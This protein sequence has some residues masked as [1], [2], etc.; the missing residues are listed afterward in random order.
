MIASLEY[1]N[2]MKKSIFAIFVVFGF[3]AFVLL[4]TKNASAPSDNLIKNTP[5]KSSSS[6]FD[7]QKYSLDTPDSLWWI[8]NK[9]HP[10]N[11]IT[12]APS[13]LIVPNIGLRSPNSS[14]SRIRQEAATSL[15]NMVKTAKSQDINL[16]LVS[17][18]RSYQLQVSVYNGY[19][20]KLGQSGAD[21]VSAR[22]GTS[23]HQTGM[24]ADLGTTSNQCELDVCFANLPEGK[25]LV[26]NAYRYGFI[27]R[28]PEGK[29]K[30][31]GYDFEPWHFR[32]VGIELATEMHNQNIQTLEE[33]FNAI[34][35]H[36]P[37]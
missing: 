8:V 15:E 30:I 11:P 23:E 2:G 22:P 21:K 5:V 14:E 28:Y 29:N 13:D 26:E 19:V 17:G 35:D 25:W 27:V 34:P 31:T 3:T 16:L 7:K 1:N 32:Y 9:E 24:A 12:Y 4:F 20:Q 10:I 18:Y 36:Q 6:T 33:F 37:Y